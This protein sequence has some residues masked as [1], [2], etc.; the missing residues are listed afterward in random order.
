MNEAGK[1]PTDR[2][3]QA[4]QLSEADQGTVDCWFEGTEIVIGELVA[5]NPQRQAESVRDIRATDLIEHSIGIV[6]DAKPVKAKMKRYTQYEREFAAKAFPDMEDAGILYRMASQWGAQTRFI[7]KKNPKDLR[8]VHNFIP[9]NKWS[10]GSSYPVHN[11]DEVVD[12]VLKSKFSTYFTADASCGYWAVPIKPGDEFKAVVITTHGQYAHRR[13]GISLKN[14]MHTYAQFTGMVFGQLPGSEGNSRQDSTIGD[15]REAGFSPFVEGHL[16]SATP[17]ETLFRFLHEKY[18]PRVVFGPVYLAEK[19][20]RVFESSLEAV[21]FEGSREGIRPSLRHMEKIKDW[22][23]PTNREE[24]DGFLWLTLFLRRFIPGRSDHGMI[25]KSAYLEIK[26]RRNLLV[27]TGSYQ[28]KKEVA[29]EIEWGWRRA[30][31]GP[32]NHTNDMG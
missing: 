3:S 9:I 14:A 15:H 32:Q 13:M 17:Y 27:L 19:K 21:G 6:P 5:D 20:V 2:R 12:V 8:I 25:M 18:F 10:I 7:S 16:G 30:K 22:P 23:T 26:F 1:F 28:E 4:R 29:Q 24:L 11:F 31:R